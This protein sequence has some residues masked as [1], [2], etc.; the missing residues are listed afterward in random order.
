MSE[1][2]RKGQQQYEVCRWGAVPMRKFTFCFSMTTRTGQGCQGVH[3]LAE[4]R[5][6]Q[7]VPPHMPLRPVSL[8]SKRT[9][10]ALSGTGPIF[11][12]VR[13]HRPAPTVPFPQQPHL[14][15]HEARVACPHSP[16]LLIRAVMNPRLAPASKP[17]QEVLA[18][19]HTNAWEICGGA[20]GTDGAGTAGGPSSGGQTGL[21]CL[22]CGRMVLARGRGRGRR[23]ALMAV[24][25]Q[26]VGMH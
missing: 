23:R 1:R 19:R 15:V 12:L 22:G 24:V 21:K 4:L 11:A 13:G 16:V 2:W 10:Q 26:N 9:Y 8:F 20:R 3:A 25:C 7:Q 6:L 5:A 18:K 14:L 17:P